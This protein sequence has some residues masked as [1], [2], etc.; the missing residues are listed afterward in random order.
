MSKA[1]R[2]RVTNLKANT[3]KTKAVRKK[4]RLKKSQRDGLRWSEGSVIRGNQ[5]RMREDTP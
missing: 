5:R 3:S 1:Y 4:Q 2:T